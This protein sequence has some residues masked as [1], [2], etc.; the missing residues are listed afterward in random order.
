MKKIKNKTKIF[1][2]VFL[3][4]VLFAFV[5]FYFQKKTIGV[6]QEI[7]YEHPQIPVVIHKNPLYVGAQAYIVIDVA[8]NTTLVAKNENTRIYPAST[9]KLVTALTALNIYP[10]GEK[11][12][13]SE[14]K[15][16]K[17]MELVDGDELT[18]GDLV[19]ATLIHSANDAAFNL[20]N[21]HTKGIS[22]FVEEMNKL[23]TD[24]GLK[25]TNFAN[26]DGLHQANHYS[27][28]YDLAQIARI[29]IKNQTIAETTRL[30][31]AEVSGSKGIVYKLET[32][33]ELLEKV[34][35]IKG[36]K[37]GW[38]PEAGG[39]FVSLIE[40][41]NK[42]LIG[43]ILNSEYRFEDTQKIVNWIIENVAWT[44]YSREM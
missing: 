11:V 10:L 26:Y 12:K 32:T 21:K 13:V 22:G 29:A 18:V 16:G 33:N 5:I 14:Y 17:I 39:C 2:G 34:S 41:N 25:N 1:F 42:Q 15:N 8:T 7:V 37:T 43:V 20:A 23:V 40:V 35:Q 28:A 30:K 19:K 6:S 4:V 36:L 9:T 44:D 27:S 38:T 3:L 24:I 31:Q